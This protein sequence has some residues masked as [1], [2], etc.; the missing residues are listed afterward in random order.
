[1]FGPAQAAGT[2]VTFYGRGF[3]NSTDLA[4][5]FGFAPP[6]P[7]HFVSPKEI[8]CESPPLGAPVAKQHGDELKEHGLDWSALSEI[9]QRDP[10][11]LTGSRN[12]FP[13]AHFYPLVLQ[14][15][16]G[17]EVRITMIIYVSNLE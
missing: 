16:V 13:R 2:A 6:V 4:C 12:L 14:H 11:P 5:R 1:M 17:V 10:N 7:A 3:V 8:F 9:R 15:A